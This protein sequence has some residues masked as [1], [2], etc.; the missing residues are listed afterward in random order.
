MKDSYYREISETNIVKKVV[1]NINNNSNNN[2][3]NKVIMKY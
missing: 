2:N 3:N 1:V